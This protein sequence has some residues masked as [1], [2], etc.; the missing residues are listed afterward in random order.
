MQSVIPVSR[1]SGFA[2]PRRLLDVTT[3]E[4][5]IHDERE[6]LTGRLTAMLGGDAHA[7]E[8]VCQDAFERAWRKLPRDLDPGHQRGWLH[9]TAAN[10]ALD[11]LRRRTRRPTAPL[12]YAG[13][14]TSGTAIPEPDAAREAL[15]RLSPHERF[16]FLLRFHAGFAHGEIARLLDISEEAARKRVY[17]ARTGFLSTY[18]AARSDSS[19]LVLLMTRGESPGPYVRWLQDAGARVRQ[20]SRGPTERELAL[21]DGFVMTGAFDDLH[22]GLYGEAPR[23]LRGEPD[24]A[25]DRGDLAVVQG[26]LG[27]DLP[28]VGVCRGHQLLNIASGGALYQDVMLDGATG[29]N[30][31]AGRHRVETHPDTTSRELLGRRAEVHSEHHQAV[32][33]LGRHLRISASSPD[34]LVETIERTDRSF[35]L[36]LQWHPETEPGGHGD[37]VAEAL[38]EAAIARA[39]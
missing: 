17:R 12:E 31:D 13:E 16:V 9:K 22:P 37:R 10:L 21:A 14:L 2:L 7:A 26:A 5:L 27:L 6:R 28:L 25:R 36:G 35:A 8:D 4:A 19:P 15:H 39:A 38:V 24:F 30:H 29:E 11:E 18:R 32:R 20:L 23:A 34:G 1:V 33:R 3:L